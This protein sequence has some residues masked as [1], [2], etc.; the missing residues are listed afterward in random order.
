VGGKAGEGQCGG[1]LVGK[2]G[3]E[4]ASGGQVD[5][6]GQLQPGVLPVAALPQGFGEHGVGELFDEAGGFGERDEHV[7]G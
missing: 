7:G 4:H 6:N 1:D 2:C 5:R 3:V